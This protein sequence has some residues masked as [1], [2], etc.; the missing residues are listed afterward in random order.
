[1]L[2]ILDVFAGMKERSAVKA[3]VHIPGVRHIVSLNDTQEAVI[4]FHSD[5]TGIRSTALLL[6]VIGLFSQQGCDLLV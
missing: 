5:L 2:R 3:A 4:L 1:M 6:F